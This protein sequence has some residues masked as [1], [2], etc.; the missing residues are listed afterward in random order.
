MTNTISNH[1]W[2]A[3]SAFLD[4]ELNS[5]E[6]VR[7]EKRLQTDPELRQAAED[8]SKMRSMLRSQPKIRAPRNFTLTPQMAGVPQRQARYPYPFFR[9]ASA[10]ASLLFVMVLASDLLFGSSLYGVM[11]ASQRAALPPVS[12]SA[13]AAAPSMAAPLAKDT[14]TQATAAASQP[15]LQS[16]PFNAP[17]GTKS[18]QEL[19]PTGT[20]EAQA[21]MAPSLGAAAMPT[22]TP[23]AEVGIMSA[24]EAPAAPTE[25]LLAQAPEPTL[26]VEQQR[27]QAETHSTGTAGNSFAWRLAEIIL[28]VIAVGSGITAFFLRKAR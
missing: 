24:Q 25:D 26:Q 14:Q 16:Q 9:L 13:P 27:Y 17:L 5:R 21:L 4:G 11:Q 18:A 1:D 22:E 7:L 19:A 2:E 28:G 23:S 20:P 10:V 3:I 8:L 12:E 6:R 15:S